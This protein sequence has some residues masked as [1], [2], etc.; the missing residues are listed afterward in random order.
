MGTTQAHPPIKLI[1]ALIGRDL[2]LLE[3]VERRMERE[4]GPIQDRSEIFMFTFAERFAREMGPELKKRVVSF[5]DLLPIEKFPEVK[6]FTNDL[7]W[8]YREHATEGTR[9]LVNLDPGYVTLTQVTLAS[10]RSYGHH[11]YLRDGVYAELLLRYQRGVL[12]NLPWTYPDFRSHLVHQFFTSVRERYHSE[13]KG[14]FHHREQ[15]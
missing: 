7:E 2:S 12:R 6:L 8:E 1:L 15:N 11:V 14:R 5:R 13:L 9:R 4:Y 10:T 3:E